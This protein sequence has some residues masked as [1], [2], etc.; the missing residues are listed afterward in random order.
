M[1]F[2]AS[3]VLAMFS[4]D[5]NSIVYNKICHVAKGVNLNNLTIPDTIIEKISLEYY[6]PK[7]I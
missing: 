7:R 6:V 5:K 2:E 4:K 1:T 3:Q